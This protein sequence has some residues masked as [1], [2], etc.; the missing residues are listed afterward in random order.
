MEAVESENKKS[1]SELLPKKSPSLLIQTKLKPIVLT[2]AQTREISSSFRSFH[3]RPALAYLQRDM[4]ANG[5]KVLIHGADHLEEFLDFIKHKCT[6]RNCRIQ[7][8][9]VNPV[10]LPV[11]INDRYE[12]R[13]F[14]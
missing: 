10:K 12:H 6:V 9:V 3:S 8:K 1:E 5:D 2:V 13:H 11:M 7:R 14:R 4:E